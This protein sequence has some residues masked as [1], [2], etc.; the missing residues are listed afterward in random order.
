MTCRPR[1]ARSRPS[2]PCTLTYQRSTG[3]LP[4]PPGPASR[5]T[6]PG[7]KRAWSSLLTFRLPAPLSSLQTRCGTS[8]KY[9]QRTNNTQTKSYGIILL[10]GRKE[11][12]FFSIVT[13]KHCFAQRSI[14]QLHSYAPTAASANIHTRLYRRNSIAQTHAHTRPCYLFF[15]N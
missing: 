15:S 13:H 5:A 1:L 7:R 8:S 3:T 6:P 12:Y 10:I 4:P 14:T 9:G 11:Q 2:S